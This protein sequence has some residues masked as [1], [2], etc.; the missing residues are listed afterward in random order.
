VFLISLST[1]RRT[2]KKSFKPSVTILIAAYNEEASIEATIRNKLALD[3]PQDKLEIIVIS[4]CS[5]DGTDDIVKGLAPAGVRLLRQEQRAGKTAALNRA[6]GEARGEIIVFSDAN[7]TY[8]PQALQ[9]LVDNFTDPQVGYVTGKML[10]T[11]PDGSV[12]GDGCSAYMKYENLLRGLETRVGSVVGVDGGIDAVRASLYRPMAPDQLPDF[13]LPLS[14]VEQGSR[15]VYE[16]LAILREETLNQPG[17]EYRMRVR[18]SLRAL[19]ALHDMRCLLNIFN[20]GVFSWQLTSHKVLR[21]GAF[22]LLI[23]AYLANWMIWNDSV[24][25]TALLLAQSGCYLAALGSW[26]S[27]RWGLRIR[28]FYFPYY[29]TLI[30]V[31]AAHA[32]LK[33]LRGQKQVLWTPRKG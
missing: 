33:Y 8:E 29:F 15:V 32:F 21:Y 10:Y 26:Y 7:S 31:A 23:A 1:F 4:D 6:V 20:Y 17:D 18:V 12:I 13:V 28:L 16:P 11:D 2:H 25:W 22:V 30:N 27:E 9:H 3:Y 14:V 19:W 5:S 24:W